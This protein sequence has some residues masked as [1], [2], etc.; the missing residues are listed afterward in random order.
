MDP[1]TGLGVLDIKRTLLLLS[2]IKPQFSSG[3]ARSVRTVPFE[4]PGSL[5]DAVRTETGHVASDLVPR[6]RMKP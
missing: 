3:P 6:L 2:G 5:F 1:K 4:L